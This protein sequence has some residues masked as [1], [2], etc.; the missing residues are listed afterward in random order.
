MIFSMSIYL[1]RDFAKTNRQVEQKLR[2][3][4]HLSERSLAQE[5]INR[6]KE[7]ERKLLAAENERKSKELEEARQLQ[8][9][10]LPK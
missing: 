1:S 5:R 2:E 10:M 9:S 7:V 3:V 6:E 8:L 4:K